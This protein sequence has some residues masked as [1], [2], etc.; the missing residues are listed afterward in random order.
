MAWVGGWLLVFWD[1]I[2]FHVQWMWTA[3]RMEVGLIG[4]PK[5]SV[6]SSQTVL[7]NVPEE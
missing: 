7:H 5:M 1:N 2:P 4:C 6:T 3:W